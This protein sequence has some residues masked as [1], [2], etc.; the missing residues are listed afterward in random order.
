MGSIATPFLNPIA[1]ELESVG[2]RPTPKVLSRRVRQRRQIQGMIAASYLLDGLI[3]LIFAEAGAV[4]LTIAPAYVGAGLLSVAFYLLLSETGFTERFKD[5]YC[6]VPQLFVSVAIVLAF[7]YVAPGV[8]LMFLCTLFLIVNFGSLRSTPGQS[9]A[10]WTM[11]A[12]GIAFLFLLTDKP[13]G[14]PHDSHLERLATMLV[15]V[16]GI[17]RCLFVGIFS[18][19]MRQSL[20]QSGLKL[21]EAYRRIEELAELDELTGSFNRRCIMRMLE[22]EIARTARLK[23]PCSVALIDLDFFKRVNDLYGHATGDELL[24]TVAGRIAARA[25]TGDVVCRYGGDEFIV[26]LPRIPHRAAAVDVA[27]SIADRVNL[28]CELG[29]VQVRVTAAIGVSMC[30]EDALTAAELLEHADALM[31]RA[32]ASADPPREVPAPKRR[33]DD[34]AKT[35]RD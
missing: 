24:I 5:H 28:P 18:S 7:A 3:L 30:P 13:I 26:L 27:R 34:R 35:R 6:V 9:A 22:E 23:V 1:A 32:K 16:L 4:P 15:F 20:Y 10:I 33:R 21:K 19:L 11:I 14:L 12:T 17:G 25:R 29:S 8:G 31:Y 2:P